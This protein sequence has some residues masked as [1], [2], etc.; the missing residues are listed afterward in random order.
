M[1]QNCFEPVGRNHNY[2]TRVQLHLKSND[3]FSDAHACT[4]CIQAALPC[5]IYLQGRHG[6]DPSD[7]ISVIRTSDLSYLS[8]QWGHPEEIRQ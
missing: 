8:T 3:S 4:A 2:K 7:K 6:L 1:V 5:C